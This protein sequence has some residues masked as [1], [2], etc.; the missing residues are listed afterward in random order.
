MTSTFSYDDT[1]LE[2][3]HAYA[4]EPDLPL[5][6]G[7]WPVYG[8]LPRCFLD[9]APNR[10]GRDL[11]DHRHNH[12]SH[13]L[14]RAPRALTDIDYLLGVS[15]IARQSA[16]RFQTE[17]DGPYQHPVD[18]IPPLLRLPTLAAASQR[19][20]SDVSHSEDAVK[21]LLDLGSASLGGARPK[22]SVRD[23]GRLLIAKF[24]HFR[25]R[26][27]VMAWEKTALDLAKCA[28]VCVPVSR[29]LD[30]EEHPVLLVE[31]FDRTD[32]GGRLGYI[33]A[34]TLCAAADGDRRDYVEI[35]ERLAAISAQ[36]GADLE[37]LYRRI[38]FSYAINN[39]DDHLRN[40]GLLRTASGWRLSPAFDLN[41]NP[42]PYANHAT[43]IR[44]VVS[45]SDASGV[46]DAAARVLGLSSVT[47]R[48]IRVDVVDAVSQWR[49]VARSHGA[50]AS[51]I[52]VFSGVMDGATKEF[53]GLS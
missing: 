27:N 31:R 49:T 4:L 45:R 38:V 28:G 24:G 13:R 11:I 37:E 30:I 5:M 42:D 26:W 40:H 3:A 2:R 12:D 10:W 17:P 43:S 34:L 16:I 41:P 46:W 6:A 20:V 25:D 53:A 39:T 22:A 14:G 36:P 52:E 8:T 15:D 33:S 19:V 50:S 18:D 47:S 9:A 1:Y 7:M 51:E 44:G 21:V 35:G 48:A 23:S 29:L 32:G